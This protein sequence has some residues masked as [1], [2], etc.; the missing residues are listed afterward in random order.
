MQC[1]FFIC[2][3]LTGQVDKRT[4]E[5]FEREA[6]SKNR[7]TW[8]LSWALDLNPEEREKVSEEEGGL[9]RGEGGLVSGEGGLVSGE[10]G[11]V[12]GGWTGERRGWTGEWRGWTGGWRVDW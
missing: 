10:G 12:R 4:L 3:Y 9:V 8:Y 6:K 11:L 7:E 2:R 5:K 1:H